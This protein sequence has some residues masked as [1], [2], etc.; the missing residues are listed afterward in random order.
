MGGQVGCECVGCQ[1]CTLKLIDAVDWDLTG[2]KGVNRGIKHF[3]YMVT[4]NHEY[5][6]Y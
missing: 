5:N 3:R 4:G 2:H 6:T 1:S